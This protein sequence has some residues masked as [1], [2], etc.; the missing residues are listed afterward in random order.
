MY[1]A[2]GMYEPATQRK[3]KNTSPLDYMLV[4]L[5]KS[6]QKR[7]LLRPVTTTTTKKAVWQYSINPPSKPPW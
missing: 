1:T 2:L 7:Q 5:Y 4:P 6:K 3:Q